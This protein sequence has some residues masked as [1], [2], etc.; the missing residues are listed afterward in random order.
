MQIFFTIQNHPL[1]KVITVLSYL[2]AVLF[3]GTA[4]INLGLSHYRIN[5]SLSSPRGGS[6]A[7]MQVSALDFANPDIYKTRGIL[8]LKSGNYLEATND[9]K[10]AIDLRPNDYLL[11]LQLGY[12]FYKLNNFEKSADAYRQAIAL[13][14]NYAEPRRYLGHLFIKTSDFDRAFLYLS[15]AATLDSNLLPEVMHL[16]QKTFPGDSEAIE[17]S[18]R[19]SSVEAKKLLATYFIK[20][21]LMSNKTKAFLTGNKLDK[22]SKDEFLKQLIKAG[23]LQLAFAVWSSHNHIK[24]V[25]G[26]PENNLIFNGSFEHEIDPDENGFGWRIG[27]ERNVTF[28]V[29]K[30]QPVLGK[31]AL[32]LRFNGNSKPASALISQLLLLEPDKNYQLTFSVRSEELVSAGLPVITVAAGE[33]EKILA[34]S[35][36]FSESDK[37]WHNYTVN[38]KTP[39]STKAVV[40]KLQR[41][42]CASSLCPIFGTIRLDD[43]VLKESR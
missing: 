5:Q 13:A 16:A 6:Q 39:H 17:R 32:R 33:K 10:Q 29:D 18:V 28:S 1:V 19:P 11:Y 9:F 3:I 23:N 14:P 22:S 42:K 40:I 31:I 25:N 8:H 38:F 21:N 27:E 30:V 43:F 35:K 4:S 12:S 2:G 36:P 41:L 7:A 20:Y 34:Q 37:I 15:Q 24:A 26:Y